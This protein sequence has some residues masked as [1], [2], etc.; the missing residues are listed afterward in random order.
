MKTKCF[1]SLVFTIVMSCSVFAQFNDYKYIIVPKKFDNFRKEN[2]HQTSTYIKYWLTEKG[3]NVVYDDA[4]PDDLFSDRCLGLIASLQDISSLFATRVSI[5]FKDCRSVEVFRTVEG[6][7]KLKEFRAAYS[8]AIQQAFV[9]L[10][11]INYQ[12]QPRNEKTESSKEETLIL[13]FKNDVKTLKK[14][15]K[16]VILEQKATQEEQ[17]YKAI[18]PKPAMMDDE[19]KETA[20]AE[21]SKQVVLEHEYTTE[22]QTYKAI[23][24][25]SGISGLLYAQ[26]TQNGFQLV[27]SSPKIRY[28]LVETSVKDFYLV[29][30]GDKAGVVFQKDGKW[31]LEYVEN[32]VM[33]VEELTIKF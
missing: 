23:E 6:K 14:E 8:E 7:S 33:M 5:V 21:E 1:V 12:Y 26:P 32:G 29:S 13:N 17:V 3:F 30:E 19:A 4:L 9:S 25:K 28:K 20:E 27:D 15:S 31:R 10:D 24:P 22:N 11:G 16:D 2:M 18:K